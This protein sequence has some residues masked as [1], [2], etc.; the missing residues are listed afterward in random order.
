MRRL[1]Q[2]V[3]IAV[4][5]GSPA[6]VSAQ[7]AHLVAN[8]RASLAWWQMN[9]HMGHLWGTTCPGDPGWRAGEGVSPEGAGALVK[10]MRNRVG[11][12]TVTLDSIIPLYPRHAVRPLCVDAVRADIN[13]ED[14]QSLR[15]V[16]G[17][18]G[19]RTK[20][21]YTGLKMRDEFLNQLLENEKYPEV[22][23]KIDSLGNML[24]RGDTTRANAFGNFSLHGVDKPMVVP[25]KI[26]KD[27]GGLRVTGQFPIQA[28]D[29]VEV[30]GL[31]RFKLG[32]GVGTNIW[33]LLHLGVDVVL[34]QQGT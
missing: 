24:Q 7:R 10:A 1:A 14:L 4:A 5:L 12:G 8:G 21:M 30:Y 3:L 18:V 20:L 25:V 27:G 29:M 15:G 32:L 2:G 16:H 22:Q 9:P 6:G 28:R 11:Y 23:F 13:V 31:S 34:D 19:V 17:V 26:W 33:K